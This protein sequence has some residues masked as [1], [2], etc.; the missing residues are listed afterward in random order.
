MSYVTV[1]Q[2]AKLIYKLEHAGESA[3]GSQV[4]DA[5]GVA[6]QNQVKVVLVDVQPLQLL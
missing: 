4:I 1:S 5:D 6:T 2:M 3:R